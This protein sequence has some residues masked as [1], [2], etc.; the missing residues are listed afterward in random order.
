[1]CLRPKGKQGVCRDAT[2]R[3]RQCDTLVWPC[4]VTCRYQ[5]PTAS[6]QASEL[7]TTYNW[8]QVEALHMGKAS[9]IRLTLLTC[10]LLSGS[11]F[12]MAKT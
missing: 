2:S 7:A 8:V 5:V 12:C 11:N 6:Q 1:M 3:S 9:L 10:L 4:L